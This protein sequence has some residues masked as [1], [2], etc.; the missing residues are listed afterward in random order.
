MG[1]EGIFNL[2]NFKYLGYYQPFNSNQKIL[3][4]PNSLS[5]PILPPCFSIISLEIAKP[6]PLPS[7]FEPGYLE[8]FL[9]Y[10]RLILCLNTFTKITNRKHDVLIL[11][12]NI[13]YNQ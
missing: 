9:K 12:L 1:K 11:V 3:P 2:H 10:F 13:N 4:F 6:I 5:T 7:A 8:K